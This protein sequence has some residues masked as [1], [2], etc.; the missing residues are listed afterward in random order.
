MYQIVF[1]KIFKY[2]SGKITKIRHLKDRFELNTINSEDIFMAQEKQ[3]EAMYIY[4]L[5]GVYG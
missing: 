1:K 5:N 2:C 3:L 4:I